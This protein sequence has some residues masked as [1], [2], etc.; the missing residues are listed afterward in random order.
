[1]SSSRNESET[2]PEELP[3]IAPTRRISP[4]APFNWLKLGYLDFTMAPRQ[5]ATYGAIITAF[6][7]LLTFLAYQYGSL[8]FLLTLGSGVMFLGPVLAFGLYSISRQI[9]MG[10]NPRLGYCF[11]EGRRHLGNELVFAVLL[12]VVFL[13]WARAASMIHIFYPQE[14]D[15]GLQSY[16]TYLSV[17][18]T[19][20][21]LFTLLIFAASAFS[22]PMFMDRKVDVVTAVLTSIHAVLRNKLAMLVWAAIILSSLVFGMLTGGLGLIVILPIIGHATWH[23]YRNVVE[24]DNWPHH[25]DNK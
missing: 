7:Y 6:V 21:A 1:M 3:F 13:L 18:T 25:S 15:A 8:S 16:L 24:A 10:L 2:K 4:M 5:S 14:S 9:G 20:G 11:K 19:V 17:G 22:L 12:L 23:A